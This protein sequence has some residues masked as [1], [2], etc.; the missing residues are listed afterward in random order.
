MY[1]KNLSLIFRMMTT[2]FQCG[3]NLKGHNEKI[4][5]EKTAIFEVIVGK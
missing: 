3:C 4:G 5:F 1:I 2:N